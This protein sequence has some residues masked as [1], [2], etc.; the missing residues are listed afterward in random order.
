MLIITIYRLL[1]SKQPHN[2]ELI[3]INADWYIAKLT[4]LGSIVYS[5]RFYIYISLDNDLKSQQM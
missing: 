2:P 1:R 4:F 3:L 5:V